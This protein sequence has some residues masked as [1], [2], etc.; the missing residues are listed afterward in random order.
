MSAATKKINPAVM[1]GAILLVMGLIFTFMRSGITFESSNG[2][3]AE[4]EFVMTQDGNGVRAEN[5]M[6]VSV[7]YQGR[8]E[9]GTV[10]DD[11]HKRGE[12]ISFVLGNGMVIKGWEQGIEGMMVGEKRTLTIPPELGYGEEG[13]GD[14]IPPNATLVFDVEL[15]DAIIPPT[16]SEATV[17]DVTAA[18]DAGV[19]V[20]DIRNPNEWAETG[21]IEGALPITGFTAPGQVHPEFLEKFSAAV[22]SKDTAFIIYCHS[23]GR[24]LGMGNALVEQLGFT[25]ASHLMGGIKAWTGAGKATAPYS[26]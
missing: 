8:L 6:M 14:V 25:K 16:L 19:T 18:I 15:M 5:G 13:A 17:D 24:S 10:F 12:P 21:I 7:H 26:E 23:A 4:L 22:P 9:D 2:Q 20:I 1:T 11:S 3:D